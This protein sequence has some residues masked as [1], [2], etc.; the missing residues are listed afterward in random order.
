LKSKAT[1]YGK[2]SPSIHN[3]QKSIIFHDLYPISKNTEKNLA[4]KVF[5]LVFRWLL[6]KKQGIARNSD[7][8]QN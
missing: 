4:G 7:H 3:C 8:P 1:F 6:G 2:L 5:L